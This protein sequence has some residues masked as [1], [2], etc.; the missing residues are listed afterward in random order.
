MD[1]LRLLTFG[2]LGLLVGGVATTGSATR[3][4][5]LALLALL[6][7]ARDR[8]L[9]RDKVQAYLWP[10]SD[11]ERAQHGLNQLIY[12][13]RH[14][15]GGGDLILGRKT[16]R[17]N[18]AAITTDVWDFEDALN[19]GSHEV[20]VRL[21]T[22]PFLDG[23]FLRGA[24]GFDRWVEEQRSRLAAGCAQAVGMLAAAAAAQGDHHRALEWLRRAAELSPFDTDTALRLAEAWVAIGDRAAALQSAQ[25]HEE[26]LRT[27]LGLGPDPRIAHMLEQLRGG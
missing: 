2:G 26:L 13:Q 12:F 23:F 8:G 21:Y 3:R 1:Q 20:A 25:R 16:L 22:G 24:P 14:H 7:V 6:A 5:R 10:E 17:L 27:E 11:T 15:L 19:S 18:R 4:R 9:S